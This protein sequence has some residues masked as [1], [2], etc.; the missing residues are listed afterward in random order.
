MKRIIILIFVLLAQ[1]SN[2]HAQDTTTVDPKVRADA[3]T[4]YLD[5]SGAK[6]DVNKFV[7]LAN[8]GIY[9]YVPTIADGKL[10]S[11][12]L[13][14]QQPK[15]VLGSPV[16]PFS[17]TDIRGKVYSSA[18][19]KGKIVVLN[20]WFI[21]CPACVAE[22]PD[23]NAL[24]DKY[25]DNP[26]VVFLAVTFDKAD[27]INKFLGATPF[28]FNIVPERMDLIQ[29]YGISKFPESWIIGKDGNLAYETTGYMP[30]NQ[31][32]MTDLIS[33]LLH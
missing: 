17:V 29:Q 23:L 14:Q 4:V 10:V 5:E 20:F 26:N 6:I 16:A 3:N 7:E 1:M 33:S 19:L 18:D 32:K 8:T 24:S 2:L 15:V 9:N 25:K 21:A 28:H 12:K 13:Q 27:A 22:M 30:E 31:Q 11:V